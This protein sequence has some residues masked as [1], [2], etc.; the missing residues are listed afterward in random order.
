MQDMRTR[1][2]PGQLE[3]VGEGTVSG[4]CQRERELGIQILIL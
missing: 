3:N 4:L 2:N 1:E